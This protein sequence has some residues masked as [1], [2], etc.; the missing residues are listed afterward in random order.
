MII[1]N[2]VYTHVTHFEIYY[3]WHKMFSIL[4]IKELVIIFPRLEISKDGGKFKITRLKF[5]ECWN[6]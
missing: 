4:S 1:K 5:E 6:D 3:T 2:E